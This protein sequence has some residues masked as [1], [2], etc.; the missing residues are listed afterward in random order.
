[1]R[2]KYLISAAVA[3]LVMTGAAHAQSVSGDVT[4]QISGAVVNPDTGVS[5]ETRARVESRRG[6]E[7]V[8]TRRAMERAEERMEQVTERAEERAERRAE[9]AED[10]ANRAEDRAEAQVE[11]AERNQERAERAQERLEEARERGDLRD[12]V[13]TFNGGARNQA[14]ANLSANTGVRIDPGVQIGDRKDYNHGS[15]VYIDGKGWIWVPNG[16]RL[17]ADG[18]VQNN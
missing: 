14:G 3:A 7:A 11:R 10:K 13:R 6:E 5:D 18:R 17:S 1:M 2:N 16:A 4:G 9:R 8:E 15:Q 12:E